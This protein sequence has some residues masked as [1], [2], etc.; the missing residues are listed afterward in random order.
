LSS[1]GG[2]VVNK[3]EIRKFA[4]WAREK[5][6]SDI[7]YKAGTLGINEN[8]IIDKLPQSTEDLHFF[9]IGTKEYVQI[10]GEQLKQ[11]EALVKAIRDKEKSYE[12]YKEAFDNLVEE[13]AY[14]WFNR[15][16]AIRF[17]EV[18]NYLPSGI[19]V[20]SSDNILKK[21][22]DLVTKP[23]DADLDLTVIEQNRVIELKDQNKFDELFRMLFIKQ[24]NKLHEILPELFESTSDYTELLLTISYTELDGIVYK[25]VHDIKEADFNIVSEGGQVEI[26]GWL[27][28][29]YISKKHDEIINIYKG[30]IK[31]ADIPAATQLFTT[32]WVVRYMVDNSLGRYWIER[33]PNSKLIEKLDFFVV[34]KEG[35]INYVDEKIDPKDLT[36][37]DPCMGSGHILVY[38]FDVL[39][40]I[41][42]ECG[43][44]DRDAALN[45]IQYNLFGMD[46]DRRAYQLAYFAIMMKARSYN[47]RALTQTVSNNLSV[48]EESNS[49][50]CFTFDGIT[51]DKEQNI[52]GEYLINAYKDAQE[53]GTLQTIEEY[54][55]NSFKK[56]LL[57]LE[58]S[59]SQYDIF[60]SAW[61]MFVKPFMLQLTKQA[62]IM[63]KK[64]SVVCTNPP[65][66]NKLEGPLKKFVVDHYKPYS[67]DL[68]S[69]FMYRNFDFCKKNGYSA[70]MTPNVWM[71]IKSYEKLRGYI[72]NSKSIDSLVQMA[73]GA[74]YKEATVDVCTFVLKNGKSIQKSLYFR[75]T[76]FKGDMD[77]QKEKVLEAL[78]E[79]SCDYF[80]ETD[81]QNFS[82]IT[83]SP[84]AYWVSEKVFNIFESYKKLK[85]ICAVKNGMSTTDN[86]RFLRYWYECTYTN[87]GFNFT[88]AID[89]QAS[90][91]RWFPYNK[92]GE[93]RKWYGNSI[94]VVNWQHDGKEIKKAAEGASGG[95]IVS[96]D[97]YFLRSI[98]WSKV[99]AGHFVLRYYPEGFLF[100]V[101]GPSIFADRE[102]QLYILALMNSNIKYPLLEE[103]YPTINYE[104]GQVASTPLIINRNQKSNVTIL[105]EQNINLSKAD[106]DSFETSWDFDKHPFVKYFR[107]LMDSDDVVADKSDHNRLDSEMKCPVE[108]CYQ[109]W[110]KESNERFNKLKSNE[111][112]LNRIFIDTYELNNELSDSV[113]DKDISVRKADVERDIKSL[114]SYAVGCMFGRYS[115]DIGGLAYAGGKWD[116]TKYNTYI[117]DKDNC[118]PVTDEE[119]FEDDIVGR[120]CDFIEIVFGKDSLEANLKY[121]ANALGNRGN[122][123]RD[124]IR[125]YFLNDFIKDHIK[126]YQKRPIY[127]LF[128]SGKQNGFKALCYMH[129]WNADTIGNMRVDYLHQMQKVYDKEIERMQE[130][131][132]NSHDNKAINKAIKR[133]EKLQKQL[134]ET[135]DYDALVAHLAHSRI[136]IDLD[137]GVKTNYEKVQTPID[138]EKLQILAKI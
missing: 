63:S 10:S 131:I 105:S 75:L 126:I 38:A 98:S 80:Y 134:K 62:I 92:G 20:L 73:K 48:I 94:L 12:S 90:Q 64:Y 21:E 93:Y 129:R 72:I 102:T 54:D 24:C 71:F 85:D 61:L 23:F 53:I 122:T 76:D 28:Q 33:N 113:E 112:E 104:M 99:T 81:E 14:T 106:W 15:L 43:Y 87:I 135:K 118:I 83:G 2:E 32:D 5:L 30:T 101:A 39:M 96:Q 8:G 132:D 37:F 86:N 45:I 109:L 50:E 57:G 97:Y 79:K 19:R 1:S 22:P 100:D 44:L 111:I 117:P 6:I 91:K 103:L 127:W 78:K 7:I 18:N 70:F 88:H 136:N 107:I 125:N 114:L 49:I 51:N 137:D 40:E 47:R 59:G 13:I 77:V 119:Y 26:I 66:M 17:M 11:R 108:L 121:I 25:L 56:Y 74:F 69:V 16:I 95:R 36:F 52:I 84:I 60:S 110:N 3:T 41:Y 116:N 58:N 133:K 68:F 128:D 31:K 35:Q 4:E 89:A 115:L 42:R 65:Y 9:D 82:K 138:G 34:P 29:Y 67:S 123:S 120:F 46:I 124:V 27:Y 55:Y 130:I